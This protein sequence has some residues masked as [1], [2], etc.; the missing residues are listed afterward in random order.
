[1]GKVRNRFLLET[2]ISLHH[3]MYASSCLVWWKNIFE[4][5]TEEMSD[6]LCYHDMVL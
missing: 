1:V 6:I 3:G 4:K 2:Y 5:Q